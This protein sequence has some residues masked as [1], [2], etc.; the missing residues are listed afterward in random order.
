MPQ[1]T[2]CCFSPGLGTGPRPG[3]AVFALVPQGM[4]LR[5]SH[6]LFGIFTADTSL[7]CRHRNPSPN[8]QHPLLPLSPGN[9]R[10]DQHRLDRSTQHHRRTPHRGHKLQLRSQHRL[11]LVETPAQRASSACSLRTW[12]VRACDKCVCDGLCDRLGDGF[13]LPCHCSDRCGEHELVL[14]HVWGRGGYRLC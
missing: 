2:R 7:D 9:H 14:G 10:I 5:D 3:S 11:H 6:R 12:Q 1:C 4:V 13:F 8:Q